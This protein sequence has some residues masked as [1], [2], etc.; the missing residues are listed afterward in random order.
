[1]TGLI[2]DSSTHVADVKIDKNNQTRGGRVGKRIFDLVTTAVFAP[3]VLPLCLV[4]ACLVKLDGGPALF[5]HI[6]IG[7]NG[8]AFKCWKLR[9]MVVGAEAALLE[10]L[11][12]NPEA[13]K[14]WKANYKL[15]KDPRITRIGRILRKTSLDELPQFW[16]VIVGD[17][18]LV[19][20]RPVVRS[21]LRKYG[22]MR[23]AYLL[24][25]PGLTGLWQVSGRNKVS[26]E[27]RAE[28]DADYMRTSSLLLDFRIILKTCVVML[29][30][31]GI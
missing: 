16:N 20:P 1:M 17:M 26:Y 30:R 27:E 5:G 25:K 22:G 15:K 23:P 11:R 13:E 29:Q 4:L 28:M 31:T 6:R 10:H 18:S 2:A 9:T 8:R 24:M 3:V 14:E 21:E 7:K 12:N 19:G